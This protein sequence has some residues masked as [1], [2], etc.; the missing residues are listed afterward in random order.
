QAPEAYD[1]QATQKFLIADSLPILQSALT[2]FATTPWTVEGIHQAI[3]A[4]CTSHSVKMGKV[5]PP[6]RIATTGSTQSP[7]LGE[8]LYLMGQKAVLKRL[9]AAIKF[10]TALAV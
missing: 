10:V 7:N 3:E 8:T 9:E 6:I 1:P 4:L 5:G 2:Q